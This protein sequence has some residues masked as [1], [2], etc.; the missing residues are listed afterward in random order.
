MFRGSACLPRQVLVATGF[1]AP[2]SQQEK[3]G[4][5]SAGGGGGGGRLSNHACPDFL[6]FWLIFWFFGDFLVGA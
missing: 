5:G 4:G 1:I 6:V 2:K 3:E